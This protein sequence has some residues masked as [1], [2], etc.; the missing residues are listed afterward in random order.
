MHPTAIAVHF[1]WRNLLKLFEFINRHP[2]LARL[3]WLAV[4][5]ALRY[6]AELIVRAI[7]GDSV[8]EDD[9]LWRP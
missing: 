9:D 2:M 8:A 4:A 3:G 1:Q 7:D 6:A 5:A